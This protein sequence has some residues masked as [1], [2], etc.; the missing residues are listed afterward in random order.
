MCRPVLRI[1]ANRR[2]SHSRHKSLSPCRVWS[3]HV[4][5]GLNCRD[6]QRFQ[7]DQEFKTSTIF[8]KLIKIGNSVNAQDR[9][10]NLWKCEQCNIIPESGTCISAYR[11]PVPINVINCAIRCFSGTLTAPDLIESVVIS[12]SESL[13]LGGQ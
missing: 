6:M 3:H 7:R 13:L 1:N 2:S 12:L 8:I 10:V 5:K 9:A 11:E 4:R